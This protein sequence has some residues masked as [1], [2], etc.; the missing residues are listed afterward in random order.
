M[1]HQLEAL[2]VR[3]TSVCRWM[4]ERSVAL[5]E[6]ASR[7]RVFSERLKAFVAWLTDTED[8][9]GDIE[10]RWTQDGVS[11]V[12]ES[13]GEVHDVVEQVQCLKVCRSVDLPTLV[14]QY[15]CADSHC[16]QAPCHQD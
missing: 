13:A 8:V 3:W 2:G 10:A 15:T 4:E 12:D 6:A 5:T 9:L 14:E 7:W 1:E 16:Q 11:A